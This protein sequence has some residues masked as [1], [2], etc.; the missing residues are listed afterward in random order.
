MDATAIEVRDQYPRET[1]QCFGE[2]DVDRRLQIGP[3]PFEVG[4]GL[5]MQKEDE[6][7]R[8]CTGLQPFGQIGDA[9][10]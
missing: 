9:G 8:F 6:I 1:E 4:M 10:G 7:P 5:L 3:R 2:C